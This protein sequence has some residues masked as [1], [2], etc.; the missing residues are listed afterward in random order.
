MLKT[1]PQQKGGATQPSVQRYP[2]AGCGA[3]MAFDPQ[4][5]ALKCPYCGNVAPVPDST[6]GFDTV[7]ERD[8]LAHLRPGPG[9]LQRLAPGA[10]QVTCAGCGAS[11][12]FEPPDVAG[13]CPFCGAKIVAQP[14]AADPLVAPEGVLPFRVT[15]KEATA[16][17]RDWLRTRWFAPNA[18]KEQAK[19]GAIQSVYLPFWTYDT[20]TQSRYRGER[21][22]HYWETEHYTETNAEGKTER[23]TRQV[24]K[25]RWY[26][27]SGH[28]S[29]RFDDLLV[30]ATESLPR[31]RLDAL[32]PWDLHDLVPYEPAYLAGH[33]A[34]RYQI[35]LEQGF[36]T[37]KQAMAPAIEQDVRRD[38]GGD[39]QRVHSIDTRYDD[40]SF[41]HLL[42]PVWVSAYRY[43]KRA[44]QV[45]VN[46]RTGE[47]QGD[48]PYSFWKIAGAIVA[49][50][51]LIA[52][53]YLFVN[54][55][56]SSGGGVD[57]GAS[58]SPT[59]VSPAAPPARPSAVAVRATRSVRHAFPK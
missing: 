27:A 11:V 14:V 39:E 7:E 21:G 8:Y 56:R 22:E 24:R 12:T 52:T 28:V 43:D 57:Y 9:K 35:G 42:L 1:Q 30:A 5:G 34:Q 49:A 31:P 38:I 58:G 44:Y 40:I 23:K 59:I 2:C 47:V 45:L 53:V 33:K 48:R 50:L 10:L 16:K 4:V 13:L 20:H 18:L 19:P 55:N 17:V 36:E 26:P 51:V 46:A 3:D 29:R 15:Q 37:A 54:A 6:E 32:E 41:K 25:T